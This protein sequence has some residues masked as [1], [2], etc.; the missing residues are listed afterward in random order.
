ML[1]LVCFEAVA[2]TFG[3]VGEF[4]KD[5]FLWNA[6]YIYTTHRIFPFFGAYN[7]SKEK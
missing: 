5:E 6:Y 1:R 2:V 3:A 4:S 7:S